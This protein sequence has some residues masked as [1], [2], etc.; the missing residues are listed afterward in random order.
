VPKEFEAQKTQ[1]PDELPEIGRSTGHQ[2][3]RG[4]AN[5]AFEV[6]AQH[7]VVNF[8]VNRCWPQ[9]AWKYGFWTQAST[10]RSRSSFQ[11]A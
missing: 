1:N 3:V 2:L 10:T 7:P 9:K 5:L 6:I 8:Q 11:A 4:V